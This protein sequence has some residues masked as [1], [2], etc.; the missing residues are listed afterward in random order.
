MLYEINNIDKELTRLRKK[1]RDLNDRKKILSQ[2]AITAMRE[3]DELQIK[4]GGK[5]Y[6]VEE[7][8]QYSRKG[9][10]KKKEDAIAILIEEGYSKEDAEEMYIKLS[11]AL[12]GVTK[13]TY[14]LK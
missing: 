12:K 7:K 2:Q 3:N 10:K 8:A 13:T 11:G 6:R 5:T 1:T 14:V 9:E 4:S